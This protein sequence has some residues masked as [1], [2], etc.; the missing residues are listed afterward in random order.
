MEFLKN[1]RK[2]YLEEQDNE[3]NRR[4]NDHMKLYREARDKID[5]N[6]CKKHIENDYVLD[7]YF[8]GMYGC[9]WEGCCAPIMT[10]KE[11]LESFEE[12]RKAHDTF[13][14]EN[15]GYY[16]RR[17]SSDKPYGTITE[18]RQICMTYKAIP[19]YSKEKDISSQFTGYY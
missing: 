18:S 9:S 13:E 6:G 15:P 5:Y 10:S 11:P 4:I 16:I 17:T 19:E 7:G 3:T 8:I 1:R 14:K 12:M 2:K